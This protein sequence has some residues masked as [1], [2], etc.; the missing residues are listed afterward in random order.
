MSKKLQPTKLTGEESRMKWLTSLALSPLL[1]G[2]VASIAFYLA[3]PSLPGYDPHL[4]ALF[5]S[6][7]IAYATTILFWVGLAVL[8]TRTLHL[9]HEQAGL[10]FRFAEA[11][12]DESAPVTARRLIAELNRLPARVQSSHAARRLRSIAGHVQSRQ[13]AEDLNSHLEYLAGFDGEQLHNS[14]G[15]IRTVTWAVPILGFLGTV[16]GITEAIQHLDPAK[17]ESSFNVVVGHLGV[18]FGTTAQALMLSLVL[19]FGT[20]LIE[21]TE[22]TILSRVELLALSIAATAF[23][24]EKRSSPIAE[25]ESELAAKLI[26]QAEGLLNRQIEMWDSALQAMQTRWQE[27]MQAQQQRLNESLLAVMHVSVE[28]HQATLAAMRSRLI[29]GLDSASSRWQEASGEW[30]SQV[31]V[32]SEAASRQADA[33]QAVTGLLAQ[34]S[35]E[36]REVLLN[37]QRLTPTEPLDQTL[38]TLTAAV[39]LLTA[40]VQSRAA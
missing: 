3:L 18:A 23:P 30:K 7:P 14:Y 28:E 11:G 13:S 36:Q 6:H 9:P 26:R 4:I 25:A 1:I 22:R 27:A 31:R 35:S 12:S 17:L 21:R 34:I 8:G 10:Q 39:H 40:R 5:C 19:V 16:I 2:G 32:Y 24:G 20:F 37:L 33:Q 15:L 38:H 29:D